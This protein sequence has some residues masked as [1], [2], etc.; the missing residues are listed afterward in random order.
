MERVPSG[1]TMDPPEKRK[2]PDY[3]KNTTPDETNQILYSKLN[4][5]VYKQ[6][7]GVGIDKFLTKE[8]K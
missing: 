2:D 5:K 1:P 3:T 7:M 4:E 6:P 8:I